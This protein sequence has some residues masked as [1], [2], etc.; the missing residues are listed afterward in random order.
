MEVLAAGVKEE[1][2]KMVAVP[3]GGERE[4]EE[5]EGEEEGATWLL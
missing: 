1:R 4:G 5:E 3:G 2:G